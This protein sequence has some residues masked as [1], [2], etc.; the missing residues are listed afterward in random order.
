MT[1]TTP[2]TCFHFQDS[3]FLRFYLVLASWALYSSRRLLFCFSHEMR[4]NV[5]PH[6][7]HYITYQ[8]L[9]LLLTFWFVFLFP[10][11]KKRL[12]LPS[13]PWWAMHTQEDQPKIWLLIDIYLDNRI[14]C[15][16]CLRSVPILNS[17][18]SFRAHY[19]SIVLLSMH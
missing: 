14:L 9:L 19:L 15:Q 5:V 1:V 11:H 16:V 6:I 18:V 12:T 17:Q 3:S 10:F 13:R 2:K 7:P 8:I 4:Y